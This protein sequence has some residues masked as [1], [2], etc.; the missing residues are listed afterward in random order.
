MTEHAAPGSEPTPSRS[1]R[2]PLRVVAG[3]DVDETPSDDVDR[4]AHTAAARTAAARAAHPSTGVGLPAVRKL[5]SV[6]APS[7]DEPPDTHGRT[8][9]T[10]SL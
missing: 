1:R 9:R 10:D 6:P 7:A 2:A 8:R 3:T 4:D 5:H